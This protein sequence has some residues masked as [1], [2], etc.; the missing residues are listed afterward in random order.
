MQLGAA[1]A[2][3]AAPR[4]YAARLSGVTSDPALYGRPAT[5]SAMAPGVRLGALLDH[6]QATPRDTAAAS[7]AGVALPPLPLSLLPIRLEPGRGTVALSFSLQGDQVRALWTECVVLPTERDNPAAARFAR[8]RG[9]AIRV[10]AG[11][12]DEKIGMDG[13]IARVD[14]PALTHTIDA[15][16]GTPG[17]DPY[18]LFAEFRN[19]CLDHSGKGDNALFGDANGCHAPDVR[20][21]LSDR[22]R[23]KPFQIFQ[24]VRQPALIEDLQAGHFMVVYRDHQLSADL[25]RNPMLFAEPDHLADSRD[26]QPRLRA[27]RS[28]VQPRM[29]HAA[30][31]GALVL[32]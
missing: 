28:V 11:T 16:N 29:Q 13:V 10:K 32:P 24:A 22:C 6:V 1:S 7:L 25:V 4:T 5:A 31:V 23:R 30:V 15:L 2:A 12:V 20:L 27:A 3:G 17:D 26:R 21:H 18:V 14:A 9:H 19:Q 8:Q